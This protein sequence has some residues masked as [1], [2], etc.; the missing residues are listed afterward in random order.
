MGDS[1]IFDLRWEGPCGLDTGNAAE[2]E[3]DNSQSRLHARQ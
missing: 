3:L 1:S 2:P